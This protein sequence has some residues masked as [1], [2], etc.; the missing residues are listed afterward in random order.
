MRKNPTQGGYTL[1]EL[2]VSIGLF[3]IIM[4]LVAGAYFMMISISQQAAGIST[5]VDGISFALEDMSRLIRTGTAYGCPTAGFDCSGDSVF[6][7]T[8]QTGQS[9][10]FTRGT[11]P[12]THNGVIE[13]VTNSGT[14]IELTDPSVNIGSLMFYSVGVAVGAADG[15]P[16]VTMIISGT[17]P[18]GK[19]QAPTPFTIETSAAMRGI[20][21]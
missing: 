19:T 2:M 11:D 9:E 20:D 15:P 14:P 1:I 17:L 16:Y 4:T 5:A 8:D 21:L 18:G 10:V 7:F 12:V 3:A 13:Q 6:T